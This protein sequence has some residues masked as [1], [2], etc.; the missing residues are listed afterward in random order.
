MAPSG[1]SLAATK[2]LSPSTAVPYHFFPPSTL[3]NSPSLV[4]AYHA[5]SVIWIERT[6]GAIATG[7]G[8]SAGSFFFAVTTGFL[9]VPLAVFDFSA[10]GAASG[11]TSG[12]GC[13]S[14]TGP[15]IMV[16]GSHE[17]LN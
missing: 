5:L 4:A 2:S 12:L 10:F 15:R 1:Y 3:M 11:T 9:A 14:G 6:R 7:I 8:T 16:A 17:P 13:H